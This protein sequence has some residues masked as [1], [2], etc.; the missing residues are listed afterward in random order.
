[1]ML[2]RMR[3]DGSV[4]GSA[5]C[6]SVTIKGV[7]WL[8]A[9]C[10]ASVALWKPAPC[11]ARPD[12]VCM[13]STRIQVRGQDASSNITLRAEAGGAGCMRSLRMPLYRECSR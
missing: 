10:S 12:S 5:C 2:I 9:A 13:R 7:V 1:M 6:N 4:C 8:A 11:F 3:T